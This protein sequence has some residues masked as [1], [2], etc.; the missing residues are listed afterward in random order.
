MACVGSVH[1]QCLAVMENP[2]A[3]RLGVPPMTQ[4]RVLDMARHIAR[5]SIGGIRAIATERSR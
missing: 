1:S 5:F 2:V 3:P 4:A